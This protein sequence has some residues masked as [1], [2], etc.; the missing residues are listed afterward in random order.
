VIV[1]EQVGEGDIYCSMLN[2]PILS[3]ELSIILYLCLFMVVQVLFVVV[4]V[5]F[6]NFTK[7]HSFTCLHS[8]LNR[9]V[10]RLLIGP[11]GRLYVTSLLI[12]QVPKYN[13]STN[14]Y[15]T[16]LV[17]DSNPQLLITHVHIFQLEQYVYSFWI[18]TGLPY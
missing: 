9:T 14:N 3:I 1:E 12:G 16:R 8:V 10:D 13:F 2:D 11:L 7:L 6:T 17:R 15:Y 18:W 5:N 4:V